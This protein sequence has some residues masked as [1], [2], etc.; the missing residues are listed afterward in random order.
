MALTLAQINN[1][2]SLKP[3]LDWLEDEQENN[4]PIL[5]WELI[6]KILFEF[7]GYQHPIASSI[8]EAHYNYIHYN[9]NMYLNVCFVL[10]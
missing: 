2:P 7:G 9:Y 10:L 4:L 8:K 1:T 6:N 5:P 3:P